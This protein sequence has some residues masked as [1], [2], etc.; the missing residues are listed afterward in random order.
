MTVKPIKTISGYN[1]DNKKVVVSLYSDHIERFEKVLFGGKKNRT[2]MSLSQI[3]SIRS[4]RGTL[5]VTTLIVESTGGAIIRSGR[6]GKGAVWAMETAINDRIS[7][8]NTVKKSTAKNTP[9]STSRT[10]STLDQLKQ[11]G[12]LRDSGVLD[13]NEFKEQKALILRGK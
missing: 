7:K 4:D 11:L 12:E 5:G 6:S 1:E 2:T 13:E 10:I 3:A 9:T 8:G